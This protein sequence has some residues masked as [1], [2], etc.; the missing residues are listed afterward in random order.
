MRP[1]GRIAS[2]VPGPVLPPP[3]YSPEMIAKTAAR[4]LLN[5][6]GGPEDVAEAMT[7]PG[8]IGLGEAFR[9]MEDYDKS[10]MAKHEH[11]LLAHATKELLGIDGLRIIGTAKEKAAVIS[12]VIDGVHHY[13]LGTLL[14]Q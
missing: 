12:F 5:R 8:I 2:R 6:W 10:A 9:W 7:M 14:D 4:T 3:D 11:A 13:D 1:A